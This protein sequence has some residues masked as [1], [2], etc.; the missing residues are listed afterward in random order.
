VYAAMIAMS[1]VSG[2]GGGATNAGTCGC[3]GC[4]YGDG[5]GGRGRGAGSKGRGVERAGEVVVMVDMAWCERE[6]VC[7][8]F[9]VAAAV[10]GCLACMTKIT[11]RPSSPRTTTM[12]D[13]RRR[14]WSSVCRPPPNPRSVHAMY[15]PCYTFPPARRPIAVVGLPAHSLS[16]FFCD[17]LPADHS[18]SAFF[19]LGATEFPCP[20][21][22]PVALPSVSRLEAVSEGGIAAVQHA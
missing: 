9:R 14:Q 2:I 12:N 16:F 21:V 19:F 7:I 8:W 6:C 3:M 20:R 10:G 5:G 18:R 1:A 4:E 13:G 22:A 15:L 11:P 17:T